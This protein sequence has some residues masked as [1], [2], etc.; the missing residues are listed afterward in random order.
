MANKTAIVC[1]SAE[2]KSVFATLIFGSS[3]AAL[4]NEVILF[5]GVSAARI[6]KKGEL[7]KI[8]T[9][10]MPDAVELFGIIRELKSKIYLCSL[11]LEDKTLKKEDLLE[12][13]EITGAISFMSEIQDAKITLSF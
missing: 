5:F 10:D 11:A 7:E 1:N 13:V 8:N 9:K 6:L 4:G 12:D 2:A 3:A